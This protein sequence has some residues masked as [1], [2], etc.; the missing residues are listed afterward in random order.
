MR[1]I[2]S[3]SLGVVFFITTTHSALACMSTRESE[4]FKPSLVM[5]LVV[6][7]FSILFFLFVSWLIKRLFFRNLDRWSVVS[8]TAFLFSVVLGVFGTFVVPGF[9][10][11]I[12]MFVG[13][14]SARANFIFTFNDYLW[15]PAFLIL[16]LWF[17]IKN[18]LERNRYFAAVLLVDACLLVFALSTLYS[19]G[20]SCG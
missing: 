8:L 9:E 4:L 5:A 12:R 3:F 1:T 19:L 15:L 7:F 11:I 6:T 18:S 20:S 17:S 2:N 16:V 10:D 14:T 13:E